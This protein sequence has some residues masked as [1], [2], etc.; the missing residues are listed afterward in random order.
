MKIS[1]TREDIAAGK[2]HECGACPV[3]LAVARHLCD[4]VAP[5]VGYFT[6]QYRRLADQQTLTHVS[7][8]PAPASEWI[9][10]FDH[11]RPVEPF[12]FELKIPAECAR[13]AA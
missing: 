7:W 3:A 6:I 13:A 8:L 12:D 5:Q 10:D 2:R 1:V 11:R 4:G 9:E